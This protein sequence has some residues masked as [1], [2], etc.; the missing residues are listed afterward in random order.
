VISFLIDEALRTRSPLFCRASNNSCQPAFTL[1]EDG[2]PGSKSVIDHLRGI[3]FQ[4]NPVL[5]CELRNENRFIARIS[6]G[7]T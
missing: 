7:I 2:R 1:T 4:A 3:G 6:L 5:N